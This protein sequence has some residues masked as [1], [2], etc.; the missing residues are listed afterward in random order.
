MD[1]TTGPRPPEPRP[2]DRAERA[3]LGERAAVLAEELMAENVAVVALTFVDTTGLTRVKAVPVERLG[4]AATWG[5]GASPCFDAFLQDDSAVPAR[6]TGG[7]TGDL[8]LH[9]VLDRL[10]PLTALPGWA[11]APADRYAQ[12]GAPH[13][14]DGRHALRRETARLAAL[15]WSARAAFETEW[16]VLDAEGEPRFGHPAYG[17]S[18]L[19]EAADYLRDVVQALAASGVAVEQIHPE[20]SPSQFELSVAA[21]DPVGAA[22]TAVLVRDT[23]R[24]VTRRA[25]LTATFAP[26]VRAEGVGNGG[27]VHLSLWGGGAPAAPEGNAMAGGAGPFGMAPAGEAFAAG[28][29][30]HLPALLA[31]GAPSAASYL[32]LLPSHWAGAYACWGLE[33]REAALRFVTG[34]AGS[35]HH[36]ANLEIKCFDATAN[37]YLALAGLL[38]AGRAGLAAGG[39]LPEPVDVDPATL[40]GARRLP[41]TLAEA[42]DAFAGDPAL[43]GAFGEAITDTV[44]AVRR[45]ESALFAGASPEEI[46][47]ATVTRY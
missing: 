46:V 12:D 1:E 20:Y 13:P 44:V 7:A 21:E 38:A 2:L 8:R 18:R 6:F 22:D 39:A 9:P 30:A 3:R 42:T 5:V 24:A 10:V 27:H 32:R 29:L 26:K 35:R 23:I 15:G 45:G 4:H 14:V 19:V 43:T 31:L 16:V 36:A 11:W 41:A 37:P 25:G 28:I 47:R 17:M 40:P 34:A 33:N